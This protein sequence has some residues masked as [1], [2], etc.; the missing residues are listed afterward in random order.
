[1]SITLAHLGNIALR[2]GRDLK[3]DPDKE[4]IFNDEGA[5]AMLNRP[6]RYPWTL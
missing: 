4:E 2:T 1:R 5:N 6:H 3:W